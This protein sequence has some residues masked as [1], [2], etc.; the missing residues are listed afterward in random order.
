M[1]P[2]PDTNWAEKM[3]AALD[4]ARRGLEQ[5]EV[6]IGAAVFRGDEMLASAHDAKESLD[7][8][9]AHA[10]ILALREAGRRLGDWRLDGCDLLVTLEPCPMCAGAIIQARIARVVFGARNPRWGA[11]VSRM[12]LL[13]DP[14]FNHR[15]EWIEGIRAEECAE[16]PRDYFRRKRASPEGESDQ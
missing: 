2:M 6:P 10:E 11:V 9:A 8:P 7:D 15:V 14:V 5:D 4:A 3:Q 13:D 16:L 1:D 12:R